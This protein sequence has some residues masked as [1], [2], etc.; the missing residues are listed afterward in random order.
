MRYPQVVAHRGLA[1]IFPENTLESVLGAFDAGLAAAEI[2]IQLS[3]D[4]VPVLQHDQDLKRMTGQA[5]DLRRMPFSKLKGLRM[6]EPGRFGSR[7]R[8]RLCSLARLAEALAPRR[9]Y[10]LFVELKEESLK[11]FGRA[12]MLQAVAQALRPIRKRCVLISF[13]WEVLRLA[14][15]CTRF[16]V[17]PV[18]R[19]LDQ[20]RRG[21]RALKPEWV[22]CDR[23]MLP[24]KGG[25][26][27]LFG[28]SRLCI[29]EVPDCAA[30][31]ALL[32]RGAAA[33][34]TFRADSLAQELALYAWKN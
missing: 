28:A 25:L 30:A 31:R 5:G 3:L 33:V 16:P 12:F 24:K 17:A 23:K 9:G 15:E 22:F 10:T 18:L 1:R 2:D 34:E 27:A 8:A 6:S 29:Y 11:P 4:G 14:R 32:D 13:D 26:K 19:S 21:A 20:W 7:F